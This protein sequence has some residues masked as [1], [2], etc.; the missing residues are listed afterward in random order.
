[1]L[2]KLGFHQI[3][4]GLWFLHFPETLL[5]FLKLFIRTNTSCPIDIL[6]QQSSAVGHGTS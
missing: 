2:A 3:T 1:M 4:F 6:E 5:Q